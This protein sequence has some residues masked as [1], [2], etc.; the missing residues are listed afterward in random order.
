MLPCRGL[1]CHADS[2]CPPACSSSSGI[3]CL[4]SKARR[5]HAHITRPISSVRSSSSNEQLPPEKQ[6]VLDR[7]NRAKAYKQG[8]TGPGAPPPPPPT[9]QAHT[10]PSPPPPPLQPKGVDAPTTAFTS[11]PNTASAPGQPQHWSNEQRKAEEDR[12]KRC[13]MVS[14]ISV[15]SEQV[16]PLTSGSRESKK[17]MDY[18]ARLRC[19]VQR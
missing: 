5:A 14:R 4:R 16:R 1:S 6:A 15:Q 3:P 10:P 9:V 13:V 12:R 8:S 2:R 18:Y 17:C 19:A 7:I 11:G